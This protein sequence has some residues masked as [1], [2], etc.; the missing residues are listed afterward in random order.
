[1]DSQHPAAPFLD[2][3]SHDHPEPFV[4]TFGELDDEAWE[5]VMTRS[6]TEPV[7]DGVMFPLFPPEA[8]QNRIHGH[9][10]AVALREAFEFY[11]TILRHAEAI[12]FTFQHGTRLLDFGSGWGRIPRPFLKRVYAQNIYGYE[13]VPL[14]CRLARSLNPYVPFINGPDTPQ[15][16]FSNRRF[17]AIISW[18]VLTHLPKTLATKWF[19][20]FARITE[21]GAMLVVT[22]WGDRFLRTLVE[23]NQKMKAGEEIH[24]YH[25]QVIEAA[26]DFEDL[27]R[28]HGDGEVVF[29]A[30]S[31]NANYGDT[32]MSPEA[33]RSIAPATLEL[34]AYD[35]TSVGQDVLVFRCR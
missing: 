16:V 19:A 12:G 33:A 8:M 27:A 20:E 24:W 17:D 25:K 3:W 15:T 10:G 2:H 29:I 30:S 35:D 11:R 26:D 13:P 28:R 21:P 6:L 9:S 31:N 32:F 14:Y 1:M 23:Q 22:T 5:E 4:E 7:Q 18:S 34:V